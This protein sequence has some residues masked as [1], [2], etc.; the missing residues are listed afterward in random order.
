M[1]GNVP[2]LKNENESH[3]SLYVI[4]CKGDSLNG[5][6]ILCGFGEHCKPDHRT[7]SITSC[8]TSPKWNLFISIKQNGLFEIK[9]RTRCNSERHTEEIKLGRIT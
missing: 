4:T 2:F 6:L 5:S 3:C 8:Y 1:H 7:M 9:E